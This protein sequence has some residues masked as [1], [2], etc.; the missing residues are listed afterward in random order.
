MFLNFEVLLNCLV[1]NSR[2]LLCLPKRIKIDIYNIYL[3]GPHLN[4]SLMA[5]FQKFDSL[6]F[7]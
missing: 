3:N 7:C 6:S 2:Q 1:L 4:G 5:K